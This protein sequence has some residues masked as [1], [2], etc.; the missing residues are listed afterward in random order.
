MTNDLFSMI[1]FQI[2]FSMILGACL[3]CW[4]KRNNFNRYNLIS[5]ILI[6]WVLVSAVLVILRMF[7]IE[8]NANKGLLIKISNLINWEQKYNEELIKYDK[9]IAQREAVFK[10][11]PR[12][13]KY[14]K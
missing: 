1:M 8:M 4:I 14:F 2:I 9:E 13:R 12:M 5:F 7:Q 6:I 3:F 10:Q 11:H